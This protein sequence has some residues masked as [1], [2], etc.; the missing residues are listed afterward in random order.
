M[1]Y[2]L[3]FRAQD[4]NLEWGDGIGGISAKLPNGQKVKI[5]VLEGTNVLTVGI[6]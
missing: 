1:L 4:S 2:E 6:T 3:P 5:P